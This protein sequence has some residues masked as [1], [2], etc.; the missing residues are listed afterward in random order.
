MFEQKFAFS[1]V[2]FCSHAAISLWFLL[3]CRFF[4][5]DF[6]LNGFPNPFIVRSR[7]SFLFFPWSFFTSGLVLLCFSS[8]VAIFVTTIW[9]H[10]HF[11]SAFCSS[12]HAISTEMRVTLFFALISWAIFFVHMRDF[13]LLFFWECRS[14]KLL[15]LFSGNLPAMFFFNLQFSLC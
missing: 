3:F 13:L 7:S 2:V 10:N 5:S 1:L 11:K 4:G 8:V 12:V 15:R 6:F 14:T 9:C